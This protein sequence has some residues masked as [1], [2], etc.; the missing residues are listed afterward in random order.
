MDVSI[1]ND[2]SG[3]IDTE[4]QRRGTRRYHLSLS[5]ATDRYEYFVRGWNFGHFHRC[6][7]RFLAKHRTQLLIADYFRR[8]SDAD[9]GHVRG[10]GGDTTSP[11][12]GVDAG[13]FESEVPGAGVRAL[14]LGAGAHSVAVGLAVLPTATVRAAIVKVKAAAVEATLRGVSASGVRGVG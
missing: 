6:N 10:P 14:S 11:G 5:M 3:S 1:T 4:A 12:P 7:T 2:S 13:Y 8:A 9:F